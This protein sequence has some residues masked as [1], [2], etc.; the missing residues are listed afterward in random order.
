M[1]SAHFH[2]LLQLS[3]EETYMTL[4]RE[5]GLRSFLEE[6]SLEQD[7]KY[8]D[9]IYD[10][11]S[12]IDPTD[13]DNE[14]PDIFFV[15]NDEDKLIVMEILENKND[16]YLELAKRI[17]I[18]FIY[19]L[20]LNAHRF[21]G[22][23]HNFHVMDICSELLVAIDEPYW[24]NVNTYDKYKTGIIKF[25]RGE[26][27]SCPTHLAPLDVETSEVTSVLQEIVVNDFVSVSGQ[28]SSCRYN[29]YIKANGRVVDTEQISYIDGFYPKNRR[30]IFIKELVDRN[31]IILNCNE[32]ERIIHIKK[33]L[34]I[35]PEEDWISRDKLSS[36]NNW[37]ITIPSIK[38][39]FK[40]CRNLETYYKVPNEELE[41]ILREYYDFYI[42]SDFSRHK[43]DCME[44]LTN[45]LYE[46]TDGLKKMYG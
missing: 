25:L 15:Q 28:P 44:R 3:D 10:L 29:E 19:K 37:D 18:D 17:Y 21:Y 8:I 33:S 16:D 35:D 46:I 14:N 7:F 13:L 31:L 22:D 30:D 27:G 6:R 4:L 2:S 39:N 34:I 40:L 43:P 20:L 38:N 11:I 45:E 26:I 1:D 42:I 23:L 36:E 24:K 12:Y 41:N 5:I 9:T 32:N